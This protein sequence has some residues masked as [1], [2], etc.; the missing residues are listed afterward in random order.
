M[1]TVVRLRP[2][3][4]TTTQLELR[5][6][7]DAD[8]AP[9]VGYLIDVLVPL[10]RNLYGH[11]LDGLDVQLVGMSPL[12][13]Q[14]YVVM[15]YNFTACCLRRKGLPRALHCRRSAYVAHTRRQEVWAPKRGLEPQA[16]VKRASLAMSGVAAPARLERLYAQIGRLNAT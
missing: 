3:H 10:L 8:M 15:F 6:G 14:E 2:L 12:L 13:L 9:P 11:L 5:G 16:A 1:C 4:D 7:T